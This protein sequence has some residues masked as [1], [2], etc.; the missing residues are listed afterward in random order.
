[1]TQFLIQPPESH[2]GGQ[3]FLISPASS[4]GCQPIAFSSNSEVPIGSSEILGGRRIVV[5]VKPIKKEEQLT[6]AYTDLLQPTVNKCH[7]FHLYHLSV[8][9]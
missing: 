8:F 6:I 9:T 7:Q 1:M 3:R 4:N 5:R 2:G